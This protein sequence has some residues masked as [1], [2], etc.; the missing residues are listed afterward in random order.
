MKKLFGDKATLR[1]VWAHCDNNG[2]GITSLA[3]VDGM[4]HF[5][6]RSQKHRLYSFFR[7]LYNKNALIRAYKHT[8]L[9]DTTSDKDDWIQRHEFP[10]LLKNLHFFNQLW[11]VF[12]ELD[13]EDDRRVDFNEF[14]TGLANMDIVCDTE[15]AREIFDDIDDNGG[16][17]MLFDEFCHCARAA[18]TSIVLKYP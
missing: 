2:N 18:A 11:Q 1:E 6:V 3:E 17:Y 13:V 9:N 14:R 5:Y 15:Q 8:R 12:D 7:N 4:V 16:G 10:A